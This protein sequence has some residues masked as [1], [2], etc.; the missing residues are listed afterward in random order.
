MHWTAL[1]ERR[2]FPPH[3]TVTD[4]VPCVNCG[5]NLRAAR[6]AGVCPECGQSVSDSLWAL[7]RPDQVASGLRSIGK[8]YLGL[9]AVILV[10]IGSVNNSWVGWAGAIILIGAAIARAIGVAELR[11]RAAIDKMPVI[12]RQVR[13]LWPLTLLEV[14]L[15]IGWLAAL[16]S[17]QSNMPATNWSR[18]LLVLTC[19]A[20]GCT[21]FATAVMVGSMGAA[22]AALL[23]YESVARELRAQYRT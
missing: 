7:A 5:Y 13:L 6:A 19:A 8:S 18:A 4:D 2:H 3:A 14:V 23:G 1:L 11:Y 22:L 20:W 21:A 10:A 12:G 17:A 15:L 9:L 16:L